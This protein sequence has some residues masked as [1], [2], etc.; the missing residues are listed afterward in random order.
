MAMLL[1]SFV[2]VSGFLFGVISRAG[3]GRIISSET[4]ELV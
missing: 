2:S 4:C 1:I 3:R